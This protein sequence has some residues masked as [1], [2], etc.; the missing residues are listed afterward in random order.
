MTENDILIYDSD[1]TCIFYSLI[2]FRY[3]IGGFFKFGGIPLIMNA[4]S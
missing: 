3:Y 4:E 1:R 2:F